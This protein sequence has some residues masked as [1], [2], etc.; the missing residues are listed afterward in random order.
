VDCAEYHSVPGS[1]AQ[2][3]VSQGE[4][5]KHLLLCCR[6]QSA[7][8]FA[9]RRGGLGLTGGWTQGSKND[10]LGARTCGI[11]NEKEEKSWDMFTQTLDLVFPTEKLYSV[12]Y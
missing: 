10:I 9:Q 1:F 2:S 7:V 4:A 12:S 5:A 3:C 11:V 8:F 6:L